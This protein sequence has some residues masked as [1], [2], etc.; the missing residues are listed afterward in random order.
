MNLA[1]TLRLAKIDDRKEWR[2]DLIKHLIS[3]GVTDASQIKATVL[4][5]EDFLVNCKIITAPETVRHNDQN[6]PDHQ[7]STSPD[8][9]PEL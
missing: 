5:L 7:A 9:V 6:T 3:A 2:Y 4:E 8:T 1:E